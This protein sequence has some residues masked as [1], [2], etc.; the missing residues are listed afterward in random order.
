M[1]NKFEAYGI[2]ISIGLMVLA[3]WILRTDNTTEQLAALSE[4]NQ[5]ASVHIAGEQTTRS[6]VADA[7]IDASDASGN[8]EKL[9]IDDVV[10]GTGETVAEGDT[11]SVNYIGTLQN[12]QEFDNSYKRGEAF[13]FEVGEGRVIA[14][15]EEG[16]LGMKEGGQRILVIPYQKA[17]GESGFGPIPAKANLVFAI[18]LVSVEK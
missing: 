14:G 12:G 15:W 10:I 11:V 4:T 9:I 5:S 16:V 8:L 17:Y 3:L 18:E 6:A 1:L 2:A 7:V 13:T